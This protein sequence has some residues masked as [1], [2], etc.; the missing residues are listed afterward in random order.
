MVLVY[1]N[2]EL[3]QVLNS[4]LFQ[5]IS[6]ILVFVMVSSSLNNVSSTQTAVSILSE[7]AFGNTQYFSS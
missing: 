2:F 7:I 5:N 3:N 4:T 6:P 1:P